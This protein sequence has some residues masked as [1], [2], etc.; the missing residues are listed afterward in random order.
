[1]KTNIYQ[2]IKFS[3]IILTM[4]TVTIAE[5]ISINILLK[6]IAEI[7]TGPKLANAQCAADFKIGKAGE[8]S[9]YQILKYE[10]DKHSFGYAPSDLVNAQWTAKLILDNRLTHFK[11]IKNRNPSLK[12][13]Y[14]LWNQP[15]TAY[16][17]R[18]HSSKRIV[19]LSVKFET[20]V[21]RKLTEE[22]VKAINTIKHKVIQ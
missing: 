2:I 14:I 18:K 5:Q 10:W 19:K 4:Q 11:Q 7:E 13:I 8:V 15:A 16:S 20:I 17:N 6:A 1:M 21:Y 9:R 3:L 22:N 12:E